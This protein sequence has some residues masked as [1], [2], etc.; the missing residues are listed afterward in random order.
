MKTL[1]RSLTI[2]VT[3]GVALTAGMTPRPAAA[4]YSGI[5]TQVTPKLN[6]AIFVLT[7][8]ATIQSKAGT[9]GTAFTG[10]ALSGVEA[11]PG[12][13]RIRYAGCDIYVAGSATTAYEVHG[14]IRAKY[15]A[16]GGPWS[17]LGL[18]NTNET[19]T[20]D[21][22]GRYNHFTGDG[23]IYWHPLTGPKV[24][25]GAIRKAWA[26]GG[27]ELGRLGYPVSDEIA[28]SG[29]RAYSDFQN[30][31][32]YW[33]G[34]FAIPPMT[35][36][37]GP[38]ELAGA[39]KRIFSDR[40]RAKDG[41]LHING[42]WVTGV[43]DTGY[44]FWR[45]RN[46]LMTFHLNGWYDN[47]LLPDTDFDMDLRLLFYSVKNADGSTQ[48]LVAL[49]YWHIHTSGLGSGQ[50]NRGLRDAVLDAFAQPMDLG[51]APKEVEVVSLK[52]TEY[53]D[54]MIYIAPSQ[55]NDIFWNFKVS[56]VQAKLNQFAGI[57]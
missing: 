40:A 22:Q 50:L 25:K 6:P 18:P 10:A 46:R 54:M 43:S 32:L 20:P 57:D 4:Q 1:A 11:V 38:A 9:L 42:C 21:G 14:D 52:I 35:A 19:G 36:S 49:D 30:G 24:V 12:G 23:S 5:Y 26:N 48:F 7:P 27:W 55:K 56:Q 17:S 45:S 29:G 28:L 37:L 51:T 53:G 47:G 34:G 41:D 44:D 33:E 8:Q 15:N 13:S 2:A 16:V 31:V 39:L 3:A